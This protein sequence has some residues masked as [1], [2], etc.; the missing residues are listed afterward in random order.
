MKE[1]IQLLKKVKHMNPTKI[2]DNSITTSRN[3]LE[4][5]YAKF[6]TG[7]IRSQD[8][9]NTRYDLITPIGLRRV[10]ETYKEGCDK[11]GAFNWEKGMPVNDILNHGIRHIYEYLSGDRTEDHLAHAAWNLLAAMHIEE[12]YPN[13]SPELRTPKS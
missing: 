8:A 11:Y 12:T 2:E 4:A 1:T 3:P 10:A 5:E 6:S 9:N 7:A 13:I